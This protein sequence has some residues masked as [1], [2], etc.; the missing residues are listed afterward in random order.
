MKLAIYKNATAANASLRQ[1]SAFRF[2]KG[3][4]LIN[5]WGNEG[6]NL[7][8]RSLLNSFS[9]YKNTIVNCET[10]YLQ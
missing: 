9:G 5:M 10:I 6:S 1:A 8:K 4:D 2:L 7:F 3:R